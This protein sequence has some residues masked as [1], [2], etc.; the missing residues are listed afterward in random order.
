MDEKKNSVASNASLMAFLDSY[1]DAPT[2]IAESI[3]RAAIIKGIDALIADAATPAAAHQ[4]AIPEGK[5]TDDQQEKVR[6]ALSARLGDAMDCTRVWSAWGVGTMSEDDF[7]LLAD[8]DE[9]LDELVAA[10]EKAVFPAPV[11]KSESAA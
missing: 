8:N 6:D 4:P 10:V 7:Q 9:R 1:R 5:F 11:P 2:A 3:I